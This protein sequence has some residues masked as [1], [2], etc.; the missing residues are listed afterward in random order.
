MF[1]LNN[2]IELNAEQKIDELEE[3]SAKASGEAAI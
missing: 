2:L 3:I 1:L